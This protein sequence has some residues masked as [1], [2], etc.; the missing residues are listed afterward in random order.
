MAICLILT[1]EKFVRKIG[2]EQ[3]TQQ[4]GVEKT[5]LQ[6]LKISSKAPTYSIAHNE[7]CSRDEEHQE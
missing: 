5:I 3:L 1:S 2:L 7:V 4:F 6:G